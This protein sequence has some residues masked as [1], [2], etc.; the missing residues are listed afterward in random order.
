MDD[1]ALQGAY[2]LAQELARSAAEMIREALGR[3][4]GAH[5]KRDAADWVTETDVQVERYV[6]ARLL[7]AFPQHRVVGEEQGASGDSGDAAAPTWFLDPIDGTANFVHGLPWFSFSLGLV[8]AGEPVLGMVIDPVRGEL[9]H[10]RQGA[11]AFVDETPI[12]TAREAGVTGHLVLTELAGDIAW[13]GMRALVPW[14][15]ERHAVL[16]IM[17]SSALSLAAVAAG[18]GAAIALHRFQ[19]WDIAAGTVI[20]RE[21]GLAVVDSRGRETRVPEG[22]L[23]AGHPE[24]V[25][26]LWGAIRQASA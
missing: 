16:R 24:T 5:T 17:G 10:A 18:R 1:G 4:P 13:A 3:A 8:V 19:P 14:L 11:G 21:A 2:T 6:R 23:V 22:G 15:A 26:Q 25:A 9:F 20:C 12:S 7:E